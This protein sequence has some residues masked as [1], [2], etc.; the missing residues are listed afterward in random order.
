MMAKLADWLLLHRKTGWAVLAIL[1]AASAVG[2]LRLD[3]DDDLR[4]SFRSVEDSG[5]L[6]ISDDAFVCF[7]RGENLWTGK[8]IA[9]L[10]EFDQ[11]LRKVPGIER[12]DSLFGGMAG[13]RGETSGASTSL[14]GFLSSLQNPTG[15]PSTR[16]ISEIEALF[17]GKSGKS[18]LFHA[19]SEP[20]I[21][22]VHDLVPIRREIGKLLSD[23]TRQTGLEAEVSGVP[24]LRIS[25]VETM[26]REQLV[27]SIGTCLLGAVF[28]IVMFR[29]PAALAIVFPVPIVAIAWVTGA[30]GLAGEPVNTLNVMISAI[31]PIIALTDAIHLTDAIR[32]HLA[33][34]KPARQAASDGLTEVGFACFMTSLTTAVSF[35]SLVLSSNP[36]V[37]RFGIFCALG[38]MASFVAVMLLTPLAASTVP[39]R[40]L[41]PS[42]KGR[43]PLSSVF[44]FL[45]TFISRHSAAIALASGVLILG[46]AFACLRLGV[47]F[48]YS[49]NLD[50]ESTECRVISRIDEEFGGSQPLAVVISWDPDT[51]VEDSRILD[52]LEAV[53][54]QVED[55]ERTGRPFSIWS[56][57]KDASDTKPTVNLEDLD[58]IFPG[59]TTRG[60]LDRKRG[61]ALLR[62][63]LRDLGARK[64]APFLTELEGRLA[65]VEQQHPG[66]GIRYEGMTAASILDSEPMIRELTTSLFT[67]GLVI[68]LLVAISVRSWSLGFA[69]IPPNVL[70]MVMAG[71]WLYL[72][73][74]EVRYASALCFTIC[75]GVA[76]DDTI[77]F[78]FRYRKNRMRG[79]GREAAIRETIVTVGSALVTTS[80]ILVAGFALLLASAVPTV[81]LF[82]AMGILALGVAL[83]ADLLVLPA[84][85]M[86]GKPGERSNIRSGKD[87]SR[88]DADTSQ[89]CGATSSD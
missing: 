73:G 39:G 12:V 35:A 77:H 68:F 60:L 63:P 25:L 65:D 62:V 32:R 44:D 36:V 76:V 70:P 31:I 86:R 43:Q 5:S 71:T 52:L 84:L 78:L 57:W 79:L 54:Q 67:A 47:D 64:L 69:S 9:R 26:R 4:S 83:L 2:I 21:R 10:I 51:T 80:L 50:P 30:M 42:W 88:E 38:T 45:A 58:S 87:D 37:A 19:E 59:T 7:V 11:E 27:N 49:E 24:A 48:R 3:Y 85:L 23:L 14:P 33:E 74:E 17:V 55:P 53:H 29:R 72:G 8:A 34:G 66:F 16:R 22:L 75:L 89:P 28:A 56:L 18:T 6:E 41:A 61:V 46:G 81:R 40:L 15:D 82:G 13:G 1:T 20:G